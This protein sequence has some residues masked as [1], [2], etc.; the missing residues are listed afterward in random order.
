MND[1]RCV[2]STNLLFESGEIAPTDG[3]TGDADGHCRVFL[4]SEPEDAWRL[5][6]NVQRGQ[7]DHS[8]S[9]RSS[10]AGQ[11]YQKENKNDTRIEWSFRNRELRIAQTPVESV[12]SA[13][14]MM[15]VFDQILCSW[16]GAA[17]KPATCALRSSPVRVV[18]CA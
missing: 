18:L 10:G 11:Q 6:V 2:A 17:E 12:S 16:L 14:L 5:S 15:G 3:R 9:S 1:T 13:V 7:D 8:N 4:G